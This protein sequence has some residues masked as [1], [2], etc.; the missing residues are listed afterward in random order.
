VITRCGKRARQMLKKPFAT[1]VNVAHLAMH[2]HRRPHDFAAKGLADCLM[3]EAD[4][5][6]RDAVGSRCRYEFKA[7]ARL[8]RVARAG[9]KDNCLRPFGQRLPNRDLVIPVN[10]R[11]GP[12][13]PQKM[14]E[15]VGKA[16]V[17][18]D[19]QQHDETF[20]SRRDGGFRNYIGADPAR[21]QYALLPLASL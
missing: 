19:E 10:L 18:I 8:V 4:A 13:L 7:D 2:E 21:R 16:V 20:R 15:I 17:I 9:G 14:D 12:K 5:E 1:M 3:A 11:L 6:K